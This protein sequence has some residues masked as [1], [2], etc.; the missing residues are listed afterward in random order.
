MKK[1]ILILYAL[2]VSITLFAQPAAWN[3]FPPSSP[4]SEGGNF[5]GN[6]T[7]NGVPASAGSKIAAFTSNNTA[8]NGTLTGVADVFTF[9]GDAVFVLTIYK[10]DS[11]N[12]DLIAD[13]ENFTLR[14]W[15]ADTNVLY[16]RDVP[17]G[18][19]SG[20]NPIE[21]LDVSDQMAPNNNYVNSALGISQNNVDFAV[22]LPV[23]L[24]SLELKKRDCGVHEL[25]WSTAS[26]LNSDYFTIER[27]VGNINKFEE[28][29]RVTA[30]GNSQTKLEY[31]FTDEIKLQGKQ[32]VYYRLSQTDFD[33]S[34]D[35]FNM[36][37]V[38][39]DCGDD[40]PISFYPNPVKNNLNI[41]IANAERITI[42][43]YN[44]LG[45]QVLDLNANDQSNIDVNVDEW[46]DGMYMINVYQYDEL[47][48]TKK[49]IKN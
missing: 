47:I 14:L 31:S 30:A 34:K 4:P 40:T 18:Q 35:V 22:A 11:N 25:I 46:N 24:A 49:I 39:Y 7:I 5:A 29:G 33:G 28:I 10:K 38:K 48:E 3:S 19:F 9:N 20:S 17:I 43:A 1:T 41:N 21:Y 13:G 45:Q 8:S 6:A 2:L 27:S 36:L 42:K 44:T 12:P 26:E 23:E 15:D 32:D 16:D 37:Y